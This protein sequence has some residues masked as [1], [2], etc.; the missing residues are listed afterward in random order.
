MTLVMLKA[1]ERELEDAFGHYQSIRRSL[2]EILLTEF[3]RACEQ[4]LEHPHAWQSLDKTYRRFRLHRFPYGV[5]YRVD[6]V[7]KRIII[8][9]LMNLHRRPGYWRGRKES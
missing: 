7:K 1:A 5:V 2:G 9:A 8:H 6:E 4:I 3:R